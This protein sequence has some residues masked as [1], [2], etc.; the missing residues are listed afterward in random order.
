[1]PIKQI[2]TANTFGEWLTGTQ[3]LIDKYNF[4][5]TS[6]N[7]VI[8]TANTIANVYLV[9]VARVYSNT[10]NVFMNTET[11]YSNTVNVFINTS[12]VYSNTVNVFRNTETVY[13]NTVNV[14]NDI[15]SY[16]SSAFN[17][18]NAASNVAQQAYN[19]ANAAL[20]AANSAT[21]NIVAALAYARANDAFDLASRANVHAQASFDRANSANVLAQAAFNKANAGAGNI[22]STIAVSGQSSVVATSN[23]TVLNLAAGSNIT[24]T[25]EP[26]TNTITITS[27]G[28]SLGGAQSSQA[29]ANTLALRDENADLYANN[30]YATSDEKLK[31]NI[32][33]IENAVNTVIELRGVRFNW[34]GSSIDQL[35]MIAQEVER[36]LPEV[37]SDTE[38][39]SVNYAVVV[40]VLIEAI[41]ELNERIKV[42]ESR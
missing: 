22:F 33:T 1:M 35:G 2:S 37:V 9:N 40:S 39:K 21:S 30:F 32:R 12:T 31:E 27:T 34:K 5:E 26:T 15:R 11:V 20:V 14:S 41:K 23:N 3:A 29:L 42:L 18:A 36:V 7:L 38:T 10:V 16:V 19:T 24:I 4:V 6:A 17:S 28:G 13:S 8:D 25:T